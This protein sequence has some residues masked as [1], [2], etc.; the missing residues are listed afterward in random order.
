MPGA[1]RDARYGP[2]MR[3][4]LP[5]GEATYPRDRALGAAGNKSKKSKKSKN[6][7]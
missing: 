7:H 6:C 5:G 2:W 3:D 4:S 1:G